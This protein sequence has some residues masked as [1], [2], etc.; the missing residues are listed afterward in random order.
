MRVFVRS[1]DPMK[2]DWYRAKVEF[3]AATCAYE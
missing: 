2:I 3:T 1:F